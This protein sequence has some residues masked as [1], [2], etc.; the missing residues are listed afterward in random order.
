MVS[1]QIR[2]AYVL[3]FPFGYIQFIV[4]SIV[5]STYIATCRGLSTH[6]SSSLSTDRSGQSS[7]IMSSR[8]SKVA[9]LQLLEALSFLC[10][11]CVQ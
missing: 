5:T 4:T 7:L 2:K 3:L 1:P 6:T 8:L 11:R 10:S 9:T